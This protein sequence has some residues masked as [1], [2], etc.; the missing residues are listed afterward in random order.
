MAFKL[1][2]SL[3]PSRATTG[4]G[5]FDWLAEISPRYTSMTPAGRFLIPHV[6]RLASLRMNLVL[7]CYFCFMFY[8]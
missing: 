7:V 1:L 5:V 2:V 3:T 6:A 4:P 8:H